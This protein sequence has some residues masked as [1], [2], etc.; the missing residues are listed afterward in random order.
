MLHV[1][2]T[3]SRDQTDVEIRYENGSELLCRTAQGYQYLRED[4]IP[5][6]P[7]NLTAVELTTGAAEWYNISSDTD[8]S[9][10]L[11]LPEHAAVYVY[12]KR[13]RMV[14]SSYMIHSGN[15]AP[16]PAGGKIV[17]LGETGGTVGIH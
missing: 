1:P 8:R 9:V 15:T 5:S 16:L 6:L 12:D 13:D 4:A 2:N 14:W 17:F 10:T 7:E 11:K 3:T